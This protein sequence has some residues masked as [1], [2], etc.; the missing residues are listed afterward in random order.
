[1][2]CLVLLWRESKNIS[3]YPMCVITDACS[4]MR[5]T[6]H[7]FTAFAQAGGLGRPRPYDKSNNMVFPSLRLLADASVTT[8]LGKNLPALYKAKSLRKGGISECNHYAATTEADTAQ[9][10][11]Q[12][13]ST[14]S[15]NHHIVPSAPA[16]K[17]SGIALAG[18]N[19][20]R[21]PESYPD[22][23]PP[24]DG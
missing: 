7:S 15:A 23:P 10:S 3:S 9:R 6:L 24:G 8:K 17:A 12:E 18:Y 5:C 20:I 19:N 2:G 14:S 1:M 16:S 13:S 4:Y 21:S 22:L 11:G